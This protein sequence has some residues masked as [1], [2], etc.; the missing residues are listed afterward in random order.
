M[1]P[2][3]LGL[4][5]RGTETKEKRRWEEGRKEGRKVAERKT[6]VVSFLSFFAVINAWHPTSLG[7]HQQLLH[8]FGHG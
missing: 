5:D 8:T 2:S 6:L 1:T 7:G 4:I 3:A